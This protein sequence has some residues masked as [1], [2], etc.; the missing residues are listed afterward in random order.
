MRATVDFE[1]GTSITD[2]FRDYDDFNLWVSTA[3][4]QFGHI[5]FIEIEE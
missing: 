4:E 2:K 3:I 1:N 5:V